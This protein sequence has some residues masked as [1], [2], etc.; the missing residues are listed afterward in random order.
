M[1]VVVEDRGGGRARC[2]RSRTPPLLRLSPPSRVTGI[3]WGALVGVPGTLKGWGEAL[4][5]PPA[6][7][8]APARAAPHRSA[9]TRS[10]RRTASPPTS[11]RLRQTS[12]PAGDQECR[13]TSRS[14][15]TI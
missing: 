11:G 13:G 12:R 8:M 5:A 9:V 4:V 1:R 7:V 15:G 10:R 14:G 2:E 6:D 3:R